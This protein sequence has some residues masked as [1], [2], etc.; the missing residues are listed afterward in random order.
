MPRFRGSTTPSGRLPARISAAM[1]GL[2]IGSFSPG[3]CRS[4]RVNQDDYVVNVTAVMYREGMKTITIT[5]PDELDAEAA[6]EAKRLGISKSEL[7]RRG[8]TTLLP[9]RDL[10]AVAGDPWRRLA[11]FASGVAVAEPGEIDRVV[12]DS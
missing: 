2:G 4:G 1:R 5:I 8:L 9:D 10:E 11:G 12:Y 6:A 3:I 7:I